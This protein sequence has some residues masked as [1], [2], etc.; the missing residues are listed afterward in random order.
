[1]D[2]ICILDSCSRKPDDMPDALRHTCTQK[3]IRKP[4]AVGTECKNLADGVTGVI[5]RLEIK[6]KKSNM[7]DQ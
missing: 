7:A 4:K 6:E 2:V 5:L 1:M 3:I